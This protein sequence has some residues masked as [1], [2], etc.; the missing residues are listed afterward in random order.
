[1]SE[2]PL[3][4]GPH[5]RTRLLAEHVARVVAVRRWP[6]QATPMQSREGARGAGGGAGDQ[7]AQAPE[8]EGRA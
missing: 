5:L 4:Q 8:Q 3:P 6:M 1:M 2:G 7:D